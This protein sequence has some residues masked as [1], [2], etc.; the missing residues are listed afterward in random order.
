MTEWKHRGVIGNATDESDPAIPLSLYLHFPWCVQKCPYCDFNSH[1]VR[2]DMPED[3]YVEALLRDLDFE[4]RDAPETRPLASIFM[5]GGTPSLFSDRAIGRVLE[6]VPKRVNFAP[7]IEIPLEAN[8]GTAEAAHFAGYVA[9][10]VN[11]LSIGVQRSDERPG[12]KE[13]G[14]S[15]CF[16]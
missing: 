3:A 12:G 6:R 16:S 9:A 14:R 11:R 10:C 4:L 8:P 13:C 5:G 2:G 15:G 7:D 1:A